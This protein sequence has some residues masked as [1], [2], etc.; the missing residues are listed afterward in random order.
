MN[1]LVSPH[2]RLHP[3]Q[4]FETAQASGFPPNVEPC[5]PG[6]NTPNTSSSANTTEIGNTP[7]P[8]ALPK[9]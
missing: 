2:L 4:R 5:E 8:N 3:K 9:M 6:V 7:P 1:D